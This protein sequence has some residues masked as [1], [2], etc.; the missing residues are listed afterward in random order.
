ML[1]SYSLSTVQH[2]AHQFSPS[3]LDYSR[4]PEKEKFGETLSL[5]VSFVEGGCNSGQISRNLLAL[6]KDQETAMS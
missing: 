3:S 6:K 4:P 2:T 5:I 1:G